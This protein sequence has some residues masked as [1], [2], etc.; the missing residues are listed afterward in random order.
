M[1]KSVKT[2]LAFSPKQKRSDKIE[3]NLIHG[4]KAKGQNRVSCGIQLLAK[5][6]NP[7]I[8]RKQLSSPYDKR[9][10][11]NPKPTSMLT[12][13]RPGSSGD[14]ELTGA[15]AGIGIGIGAGLRFGPWLISSSI[16]RCVKFMNFT[17]FAQKHKYIWW[18]ANFPFST[19]VPAW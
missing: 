5:Q 10:M 4:H 3:A 17:T 2:W 6:W 1:V 15:R 11:I 12:H 13:R 19:T 7:R 18:K 9:C 14:E 16:W 8:N